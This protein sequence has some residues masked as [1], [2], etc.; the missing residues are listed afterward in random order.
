MPRFLQLAVRLLV[1]ATVI[2]LAAFAP[3]PARATFGCPNLCCN[4]S[5][6]GVYVCH[7]S[8]EGC[9]CSPFCQLLPNP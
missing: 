7:P 6:I 5:C 4:P 8:P 1:L 3:A 9:I 2:A